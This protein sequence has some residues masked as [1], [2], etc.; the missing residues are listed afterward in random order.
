MSLSHNLVTVYFLAFALP[1]REK[2]FKDI[3]KEI[4]LVYCR[5]CKASFTS[6]SNWKIEYAKY[7]EEGKKGRVFQF[8]HM[9]F[10][11]VSLSLKH[12]HNSKLR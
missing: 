6:F 4:F 9:F 2:L 11:Y 7:K 3:V 8:F 5:V 1:F 12:T 10:S